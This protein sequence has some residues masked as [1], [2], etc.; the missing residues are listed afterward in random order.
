M[1]WVYSPPTTCTDFN[2]LIST[3]PIKITYTMLQSEDLW[4]CVQD[5]VRKAGGSIHMKSIFIP[6]QDTSLPCWM[7]SQYLAENSHN[8]N[9][10]LW[11]N[12]SILQSFLE[13]P[14]GTKAVVPTRTHFQNPL[15]THFSLC[16]KQCKCAGNKIWKP[17]MLQHA[18]LVI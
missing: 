8:I 4:N 16:N 6:W 13:D 7:I 3:K 10:F 2:E 11:S 12:N 17:L 18:V 1:A 9:R 5:A 15:F 14:N